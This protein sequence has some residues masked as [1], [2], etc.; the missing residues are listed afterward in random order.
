[1]YSQ[2][3]SSMLV[4]LG[5]YNW[6]WIL[7]IYICLEWSGSSPSWILGE[8][9]VVGGFSLGQER[10][11]TSVKLRP[12]TPP[13]LWVESG[14][15]I[16]STSVW[17]CG[18]LGRRVV[19]LDRMTAEK[20]ENVIMAEVLRLWKQTLFLSSNSLQ[21]WSLKCI[22]TPEPPQTVSKT[23]FIITIIIIIPTA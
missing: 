3:V 11:S 15:G 16:W 12:L 20:I 8:S 6:W 5:I 14:W 1:M 21:S 7:F 17:V 2:K 23:F 22:E 9:C 18:G 19:S 4:I 13:T 10:R